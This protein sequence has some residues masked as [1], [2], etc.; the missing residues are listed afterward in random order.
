[1]TETKDTTDKTLRG[2]ARKPLSLQR[3]VESG[4]VRQNFSHGRSKSVVVEKR[5]TRKL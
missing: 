3:T 4:H 5:K 1:M 2:G